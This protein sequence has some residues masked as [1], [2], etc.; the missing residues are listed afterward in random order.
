MIKFKNPY[1]FSVRRTA[2]NTIVKYTISEEVLCAR[3]VREGRRRPRKI[4]ELQR[5]TG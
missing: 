4:K 5:L 2:A 3:T 1:K